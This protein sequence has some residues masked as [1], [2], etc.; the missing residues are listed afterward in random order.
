MIDTII[1]CGLI[2]FILYVL[3]SFKN[4]YAESKQLEQK[5]ESI[6]SELRITIIKAVQSLNKMYLYGNMSYDEYLIEFEKNR[7]MLESCHINTSA[8][9]QLFLQQGKEINKKAKKLL[10]LSTIAESR[11]I[12]SE[13]KFNENIDEALDSMIKNE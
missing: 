12:I 4:N 11:N 5:K 1:I 9:D 13:E 10:I 8:I 2:A 7:T 6:K 3:A